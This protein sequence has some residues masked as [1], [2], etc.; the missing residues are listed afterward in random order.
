MSLIFLKSSNGLS[1]KSPY[2]LAPAYLSNFISYIPTPFSNCSHGTSFV[3]Q[4]GRVGTAS[5]SVHFLFLLFGTRFPQTPSC[6]ALF[7]H[8]SLRSDVT[9]T[10][11]AKVPSLLFLA[12]CTI[13]SLPAFTGISFIDGGDFIVCLF[14]TRMKMP[15]EQGLY[16]PCSA[17]C[18][19]PSG[20]QRAWHMTS[21][22]FLLLN[23]SMNEWV[24]E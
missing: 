2:N 19:V 1:S 14:L 13:Y 10:L 5:G 6:L 22:Q 24:S 11:L 18:P 23:E 8:S 9:L 17:V 20:A 7:S 15:P 3:P 16:L 4:T 12:H 21:T